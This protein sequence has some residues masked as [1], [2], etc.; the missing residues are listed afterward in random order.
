MATAGQ[1][2]STDLIHVEPD[3]PVSTAA[4]IMA[5]AGVGSALVMEGGDLKGIFTERDMLSAL[6]RNPHAVLDSP[7]AVWMTE[8]PRTISPDTS[9]GD[10]AQQMIRGGFRHLPIVVD[11]APVGIVSLR[12]LARALL[13]R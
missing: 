12:D 1:I 7:V 11:G 13:E 10:A 4:M 5:A 8:N 6:K 3:D 9:V 2:M